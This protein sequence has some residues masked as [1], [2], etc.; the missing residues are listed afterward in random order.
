[1]IETEGFIQD[2]AAVR[3]RIREA[4]DSL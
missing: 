2:L 3:E 1:V 4:G